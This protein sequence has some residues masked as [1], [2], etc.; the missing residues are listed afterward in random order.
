MEDLN[1]LA[2]TLRD[3]A[4]SSYRNTSSLTEKE[5]EELDEQIRQEAQEAIEK[6]LKGQVK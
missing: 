1:E 2:R 6:Y 5:E 4:N 3:L